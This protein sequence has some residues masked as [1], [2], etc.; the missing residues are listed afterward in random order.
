M[1]SVPPTQINQAMMFEVR[2]KITIFGFKGC[3]ELQIQIC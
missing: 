1:P 2:A 3:I